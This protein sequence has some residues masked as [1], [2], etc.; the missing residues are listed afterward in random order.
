M[1]DEYGS[2]VS[3]LAE[4]ANALEPVGE[5]ASAAAGGNPEPL[6][7]ELDAMGLSET[8][9]GEAYDPIADRIRR[10]GAAWDTIDEVVVEP[11]ENDETPDLSQIDEV[12]EAIGTMFEV[13]WSLG[14]IT[15]PE[16]DIDDVGKRI[17][18]YLL[19]TYLERNYTMIWAGF[20]LLGVIDPDG[21]GDVGSLDLTRLG[22]ALAN[23]NEAIQSGFEWGTD[24]FEPYLVLFYLR[25]LLSGFGIDGTLEPVTTWMKTNVQELGTDESWPEEDDQDNERLVVDVLSLAGEVGSLDVDISV[26]P[27]PGKHGDLPGFAVV[28]KA[29]GQGEVHEQIDGGWT[30]NANFSAESKW[31][32]RLRPKHGGGADTVPD[33]APDSELH[34]EADLTYDPGEGGGSG[35]RR[36]LG[37][38]DGTGV[39]IE[40]LQ[41]YLRV[42]YEDDTVSFEV[43]FPIRGTIYT[44]PPGGFVG[45]MLPGEHSKPFEVDIGWSSSGGLFVER[46]ESI[47]ASIPIRGSFGPLA[48]DELYVDL[49]SPDGG[50]S[51]GSADSGPGGTGPDVSAPDVGGDGLATGEIAFTT[52]V[53][54]SVELGP[55][56]ARFKRL[57]V[58]ARQTGDAPSGVAVDF[59]FP[60]GI[61]ISV[62]TDGF[63]GGGY[64][65]R[66]PER[67]RYVGIVQLGFEEFTL[68]AIGVL[69]TERPD[70]SDGFS[71]LFILNADDLGIQLGAG[72]M[73]DGVGG[74]LGINHSVKSRRIGTAVQ[75]DSVGK[76]FFPENPVA[77]ANRVI[78]DL[79][80]FFPPRTGRHVFGPVAKISWLRI[81]EGEAGVVLELPSLTFQL[82]G[83]IGGGLPDRDSDIVSLNMAFQGSLDPPNSRLALDASLYD[84]QIA[85]FTLQGDMALRANWGAEPR[86]LLSIGGWNPRYNPPGSFPELDRVGATLGDPGGNPRLELT[87]YLAITSN[88]FQVGAK[89]YAMAKAGP[90]KAEGHL[91]FD[92]LFQFSP[93]K[94]VVD[95][96]ASIS[97]TVH[98]KG[99][100]ITLD[101]TLIGPGP[102]RIEGTLHINILFIDLSV[103]L[104]V[105]IGPSRGR[106]Q[107]PRSRVLPELREAFEDPI[108]WEIDRPSGETGWVTLQTPDDEMVAHPLATLGVR[109]QV[110]PLSFRL[111]KFRDARPSGY[112]RFEISGSDLTGTDGSLTATLEAEFA[113]AKFVEMSNDEKMNSP[114]F[115]SHPAGRKLEAEGIYCGFEQGTKAANS[116]TATLGYEC[117][118]TDRPQN[119]WATPLAELGPFATPG[120]PSPISG[121]TGQQL[122]AL[123]AVGAVAG[124][125]ARKRS[126]DRFTPDEGEQAAFDAIDAGA[127]ASVAAES[128][129]GAAADGGKRQVVRGGETPEEGGLA[130]SVSMDEVNYAVVDSETLC[131]IRPRDADDS[132]SKAQAQR[133][134][135]CLREQRPEHAD[136]LQI[137]EAHRA[138]A[139]RGERR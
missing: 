5:A 48:L 122:H 70:G 29:F 84:S 75:D 73:L 16:P 63:S 19:I 85:G 89:A 42:D 44:E 91:S 39:R 12:F 53:S 78:S 112:T 86:F 133:A 1:S 104:N 35:G 83:T 121:L 51:Q 59:R 69:R 138:R 52:S 72:F 81:L 126:R 33:D 62:D 50:D 80:R 107:L 67:G 125:N 137:V 90:A 129:G 102:F 27:V 37:T 11:V 123:T 114:A 10:I 87:G 82:V 43:R 46:G 23:P 111:E 119:N 115:E 93:F 28:P 94:F 76:L 99:L 45:E 56:T 100:T 130:G 97:V 31:A 124:S 25:G 58:T 26:V 139:P 65:Q 20:S 66:D 30:F 118:V 108:N 41:A 6:R 109:Q 7:Q 98:G 4:I 134:L 64:L 117:K 136:R 34:G 128:G 92:A 17:L 77:N 40:Y 135:D 13:L 127:V 21:P 38:G 32:L 132:L 49:D 36:V 96:S 120:G 131:R 61:G 55:V 113:P 105:T 8:A 110:T 2:E 101:G 103:G 18:D 95:F 68:N 22:P 60:D 79:E 116:K 14:A 47:E 71:L 15:V 106:E 3:F 9:L 54:G 57:G 74:L 88:T 24:S